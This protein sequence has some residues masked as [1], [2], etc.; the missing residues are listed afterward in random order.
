MGQRSVLVG[1]TEHQISTLTELDEQETNDIV[2]AAEVS[3]PREGFASL[4]ATAAEK[5]KTVGP[6]KP[7]VAE[8]R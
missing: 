5:F 7:A 3:E 1:V 2:G 6:E 4:L 8:T